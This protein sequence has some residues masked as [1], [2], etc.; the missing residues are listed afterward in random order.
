MGCGADA[1]IAVGAEAMDAGEL[2]KAAQGSAARQH[3][4]KIDGLCRCFMGDV[5]A[6]FIMKY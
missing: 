4:D 2:G 6:K 5:D 3:G 1:V